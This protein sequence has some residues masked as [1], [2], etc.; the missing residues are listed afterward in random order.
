MSTTFRHFYTAAPLK[1]RRN[2]F[3]RARAKKWFAREHPDLKIVTSD[4]EK[5]FQ[6]A[7]RDGER[8]ITD[9]RWGEFRFV[10]GSPR[11]E[12]QLREILGS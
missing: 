6:V 8:Q 12:K 3:S 9:I 10:D 7:R 11:R 5:V 2:P 1:P 4:G